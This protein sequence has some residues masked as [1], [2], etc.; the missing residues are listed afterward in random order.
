M[1]SV[2]NGYGQKH[3]EGYVHARLV[4]GEVV[5]TAVFI[6]NQSPTQSVDGKMP[7]EVWHGAKPTIHFFRTFGCVAH[8]KQGSKKLGKLDDRS[9]PMVF[10]G[11]KPGSRAWRFYNPVTKRV[12]VSHDAIFEED[13]P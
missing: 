2:D 1:K 11:Y 10:I 4:V 9:T 5:A 8:V 13:R 7:Y 12:H 6:L 3:V